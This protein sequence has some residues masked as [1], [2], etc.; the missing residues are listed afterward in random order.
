[1][2]STLSFISR[3]ETVHTTRIAWVLHQLWESGTDKLT[4]GKNK[5]KNLALNL[6]KSLPCGRLQGQVLHGIR[7]ERLVEIESKMIGANRV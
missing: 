7:S 2:C 1:M 4:A 5:Q 6:D 3:D